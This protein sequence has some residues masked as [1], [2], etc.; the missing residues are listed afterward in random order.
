M[1]EGRNLRS[2]ILLLFN[3]SRKRKERK[4]QE[5]PEGFKRRAAAD[6]RFGAN[7]RKKGKRHGKYAYKRTYE[8]NIPHN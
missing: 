6:A 1:V 2:E 4:T 5:K 3:N 7:R 8:H